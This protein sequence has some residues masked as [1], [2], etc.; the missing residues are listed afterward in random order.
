[1]HIILIANMLYND[2]DRYCSSIQCA[3]NANDKT[4]AADIPNFIIDD[5]API[6][7]IGADESN[8]FSNGA[9]TVDPGLI[10]IFGSDEIYRG[11]NS[12]DSDNSN[13]SNE[14]NNDIIGDNDASDELEILLSDDISDDSSND[15]NIIGAFI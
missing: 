14:F 4:G 13:E 8:I 11:C 10:A 7:I 9:S 6:V 2:W 5:I 12:S 3:L 15:L 1:M